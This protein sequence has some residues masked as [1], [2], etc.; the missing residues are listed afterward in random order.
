M[1]RYFNFTP[2]IPLCEI[3]NKSVFHVYNRGDG[4]IADIFNTTVK[5]SSYLNCLVIGEF[6]YLETISEHGMPVCQVKT[7]RCKTNMYINK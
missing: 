3:T 6:E 4:W 1:K 2:I 7:I 5:M